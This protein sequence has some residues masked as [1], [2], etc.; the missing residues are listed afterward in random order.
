MLKS[1]PPRI[2]V[3]MP[4]FNSEK[5]LRVAI[6][7]ILKQTFSD[8][9]F[10]IIDD[11]SIDKSASIAEEYAAVDRRIGFKRNDT[12]KGITYSLNL[13]LELAQGEL[14]ARMDADDISFPER[15]AAQV[16]F[17]DTHS[18]I[19]VLGTS[20]TL[21]DPKGNL[22]VT[23]KFPSDHIV[24]QWRLCFFQNPII[25]PSVMMR[26][27]IVETANG[28]DLR[29]NSSQD[30]NLWCR[31][32]N[33]TRLAN[34]GNTFLLL[35][36]HEDSISSRKGF[37]Q[38]KNGLENSRLLIQSIIHEDISFAELE[39]SCRAFRE[40]NKAN[41]TE[42][43][44]LAFLKY[45]IGKALLSDTKDPI[46][47]V[48]LA[49]IL[50][51]ELER[52]SARFQFPKLRDEIIIWIQDIQNL[53]SISTE[54]IYALR[55]SWVEDEIFQCPKHKSSL[56]HEDSNFRC[57][58]GCK[59]P[60]IGNIPRFIQINECTKKSYSPWK[61]YQ[62]SQL[63]SYTGKPIN[64]DCVSRLVGGD[65]GI[66]SNKLVLEIGCGTGR[67]TEILL[68]LGA[69]VLAADFSDIV[70]LNYANCHYYQNY[71]A[72]QADPLIYSVTP[73]LFDIV[74]GIGAIE[75]TSDPEKTIESLCGLL[76]PGGM[77]VFDH[78]SSKCL[79]NTSQKLIQSFLFM[80]PLLISI[81]LC[82]MLVAALWP[83][84]RLFWKFR[85]VQIITGF[86]TRLIKWSPI[87]DLMGSFPE[88]DRD[89]LYE[90]TILE[91]FNT[92]RHK[93]NNG[94][95]AKEIQKVLEAEGMV[96]IQIVSVG[97]RVKVR[98]CKPR[99]T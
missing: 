28:Y 91:T 23:I 2:S 21:I 61:A 30:F 41:S 54:Q 18:E 58:Q 35:R 93:Y 45:R 60:I 55:G 39:N 78:H 83:F 19:G 90:W 17:L 77:L 3:I 84:H 9:E 74:F 32:S 67:F 8:F 81:I 4:V 92:L 31:L 49:N 87:V 73:E 33:V 10:I 98:A 6:E 20:A 48:I 24:L 63:D 37:E 50:L 62:R 64:R 65:F 34:L 94:R 40:P 52:I 25:H 1:S 43:H 99:M 29:L 75:H 95:S 71:L 26:K 46:E 44:G 12:N 47:K 38:Q 57:E 27:A 79:Y 53:V 85:N 96:N 68:Q 13:G 66:F 7:S 76:K 5:Y 59:F 11:G 72:V 97:D 88:L 14:I 70:E 82:R 15:L 89:I 42:I 22:G 80:T 36:K 56:N 16:S 69:K 86:C 51:G